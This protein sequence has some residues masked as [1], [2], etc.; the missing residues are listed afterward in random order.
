MWKGV[1]AMF[2]GTIIASVGDALLS[3]GLRGLQRLDWSAPFWTSC[4]H[5]IRTA[6]NDPNIVLG[7]ACHATFFGMLLLSFSWGDL[8]LVLPISAF[9]YVFAAIIAKVYLKEDV[10]VFRWVGTIII[11]IGIFIVLLGH[12]KA[13]LQKQEKVCYE[14]LS[15][16]AKQHV[17]F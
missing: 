6:I 4:I 14:G 1:I 16:P 8:S 11:V 15:S 3:K 5:Y 13:E 17:E 7:V 10:D 2:I 12:G 9:T